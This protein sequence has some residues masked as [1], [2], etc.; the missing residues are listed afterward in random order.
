MLHQQHIFFT[1]TMIISE[2]FKSTRQFRFVQVFVSDTGFIYVYFMRAQRDYIHALCAFSKEV[3]APAILVCDPH[4]SQTSDDAKTHCNKIGTTLGI[5]EERTQWADRAELYIGILKDSVR[6]DLR[7]SGAPVVLWDYCMERRVAIYNVTARDDIKL[8]GQTP[9]ARTFGDTPDILNLV[10]GWYDW[11]YYRDNKSFPMPREVLGRVLGP[12]KNQGN[13]M[14]QYVLQINGKVVVRRT[15]RR[16]RPDELAASNEVE[17]RRRFLFDHAI[18]QKLGTS[19]STQPV[20]PE[21]KHQAKFEDVVN[22]EELKE[23][24]PYHLEGEEGSPD[25]PVAD[26]VDAQ[27]R[28]LNDAISFTDALIGVEVVLSDP[29][30]QEQSKGL[31]KVL[32]TA[33]DKDGK[34]IDS[35]SEH[36]QLNTVLYEVQCWDGKVRQ[37]AANVIAENILSQVDLDGRV[38]I[39]LRRIVDHKREAD[40]VRREELTDSKQSKLR[41][42]T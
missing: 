36:P 25:T 28:P 23:E 41:F 7:D 3:G 38:G 5:L 4:S 11:A 6:K 40:A 20:L 26:V 18:Q 17:S 10:W 14:A 24:L 29:A 12:A 30:S 35:P 27:G 39:H 16:L 19:Y 21:N 1:D 32:R 42:T 8:G 15:L 22:N 2:K 13:E 37:Y 9:H 34:V 31:C 33:V